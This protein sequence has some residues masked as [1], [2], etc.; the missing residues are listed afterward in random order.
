[1]HDLAGCSQ[2]LAIHPL[3]SPHSEPSGAWEENTPATRTLEGDGARIYRGAGNGDGKHNKETTRM[4]LAREKNVRY[5]GPK[6]T[7]S[8][9][10]PWE[11]IALYDDLFA[12]ARYEDLISTQIV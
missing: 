5:L 1:M 10:W 11:W 2:T 8:K 3:I 6:A 4:T 9:F 7:V 12:F